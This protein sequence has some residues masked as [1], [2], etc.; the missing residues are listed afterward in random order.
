MSREIENKKYLTYLLQYPNV[1]DL[2]QIC[3]D[4]SIKGYSKLKKSELIEFILDSLAEEE[5]DELLNQK[6]IDIIT[7]GINLAINKITGNDQEMLM[8]IKLVNEDEHEIELRF[9]GMNWEVTSY[10]AIT[11][12]NIADPERDC[13]C[14]IGSAMGLC[15]HF[16][17]G[18]IYSLKKGWFQIKNWNLTILPAN[19]INKIRNITIKEVQ[20]PGGEM[21]IKLIDNSSDD[22]TFAEFIDKSTTIYDGTVQ[23]MEKK[24]QEFQGNVSVY[25]LVNIKNAKIGPRVQ[26]KSEFRE[27]DIISVDKLTLR[28]SEKLHDELSL[29]KDDRISGNGKLTKD[30]FLKMHVVKNIRK[31]VK[32]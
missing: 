30:T 26:K 29:K 18:F 15:G 9:K 12:E 11:D 21:S 17:V 19:F 22:P 10:L 16:W 4:F 31:L 5:I 32:L 25:F 14:R 13:D 28:I 20:G 6:E 1:K 24:E 27:E 2:K 7:E 3:R 8:S 23:D